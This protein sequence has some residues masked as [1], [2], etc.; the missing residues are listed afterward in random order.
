MKK[1]LAS[2]LNEP[3]LVEEVWLDSAVQY[4]KFN[5]TFEADPAMLQVLK[6]DRILDTR[7]AQIRGSIAHIPVHGPI[8]AK[9]NMLTEMLGIGCA[10]SDMTRDL[11]AVLDNPDVES[12][13]LDIDSPGGTV[14]GVNEASNF[15]KE[16][17]KEK[18]I[19][20]YISGTGASAAY[21]LASAA[22]EIV[23]DATSR[24]GSIGVVC[25]Y[26]NPQGDDEDYVE[27]VNTASP[28]K[29]PDV[30]TEKG[31]KV[32][33]AE[34]DDLA[35]V[36]IG[37]IAE[38]R[39]VSSTTVVNDFG[40]GGVLVGQKAVAAGMADRLG[41]FEGLMTENNNYEGDFSMKLTM[42]KLKAD[43]KEIYDAVVAS[44]T[45]DTSALEATHA[46]AISA[47][48]VEISEL[49][50]KLE[51][52]KTNEEGLTDRVK[53]LEKRDAIRDEESIKS[54]ADG[55]MTAALSASTLPERMH[56]KVGQVDYNKHVTDGTF[57][58]TAY[59]TAVDAEIKDWEDT[60]GTIAAPVQGVVT[61]IKPVDTEDNDTEAVDRM[62]AHVQNKKEA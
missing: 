46:E 3:W 38:N 6:S 53:A 23:L 18:P 58:S 33:T 12:I 25:A 10:L 48:D 5:D 41:S 35:D 24:V 56:A 39:N 28:N 60:L 21:W 34:L 40:H 37:T 52:S 31:R 7:S 22:S 55:I 61:P 51:A 59:K 15:I 16:G 44:V 43:H 26:P 29:R 36:F 4:F 57:D 2:L 27:V 47:K 30:S 1:F 19:T 9:P 45:P 54:K 49:N 11:Q 14:T 20:A 13:V 42:D 8:F 62:L 32:V 50:T 17:S